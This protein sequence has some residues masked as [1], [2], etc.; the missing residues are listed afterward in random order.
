MN[1]GY[2]V[3][4]RKPKGFRVERDGLTEK[5]RLFLVKKAQARVG[6]SRPYREVCIFG[7]PEL[8]N[9]KINWLIEHYKPHNSFFY[10]GWFQSLPAGTDIHPH[11]DNDPRVLSDGRCRKL[12]RVV[13]LSLQGQA[14]FQIGSYVC[15]L[16][17]GDVSIMEGPALKVL[18]GVPLIREDRLTMLIRY[19]K[20]GKN[21]QVHS[22]AP[23]KRSHL[24]AMRSSK[25]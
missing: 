22:L 3:G 23:S 13:V 24:S 20:Y 4:M 11:L 9:N 8:N 10:G 15:D 18:H 21:Y 25:H 17:A 14:V 12:S 1:S 6:H 5:D 19:F 16:K 2:N 7:P